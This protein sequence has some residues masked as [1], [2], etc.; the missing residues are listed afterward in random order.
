MSQTPPQRVTVPRFVAAKAE[1]RR[2]VVLT[3]YDFPTAR[4]FD[5]A[6]VD[7]L[8]VGDTLGTVV[9]GRPTTLGV[10]MDQMVYHAEMVSR[11][12]ERALV[13]AD[14]PFLSYQAE[15]SEAVRNAGRLIKEAGAHAVK[16]EGGR[17]SA[18]TIRAIADAHIPIM[19]HIGLTPQSIHKLGAYKVQRAADDLLADA[20]AVEEAGAF[21]VVLESMPADLAG[22]VTEKLSIPTIGIGAGPRCD[23][24]VL[25]W[26]DALGLSVEFHAKFVKRF[27]SVQEALLAGAKAYCDEVRSG[28]FP[29]AAHSYR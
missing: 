29:D 12:A 20:L 4:I 2:L 3:A 1:K 5:E 7:C 13:V 19:G 21:S 26:T 10:T 18:A 22:L 16:L 27:A 28:K 25:V 6:G 9:Q 8:L 11:A 15:V 17:R 23:G 24:Q 14:L